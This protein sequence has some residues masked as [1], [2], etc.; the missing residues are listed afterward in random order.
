MKIFQKKLNADFFEWSTRNEIESDPVRTWI[1]NKDGAISGWKSYAFTTLFI[2]IN[3]G[4][5]EV[6]ALTHTFL[7]IM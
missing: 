7:L 6:P 5:F 2:E 3:L 4:F 1:G